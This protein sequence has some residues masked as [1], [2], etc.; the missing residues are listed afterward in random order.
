MS[1]DILQ[2][3]IK[4]FDLQRFRRFFS[5][6]NKKFRPSEDNLDYYYDDNF[7][8]GRKLGELYLEDGNL[9]I[10]AFGVK[11]EL[12]ER[13]GKK[14][15]YNLGRSILKDNNFQ[16][17]NVGIFVF[18]DQNENFRFSLIYDIPKGIHR[19]WN[20]FRRFT[21]FINKD[22]TNKTFLQRIGDGDFS[23][24][25][26]IKDAFSVEK[27]TK[28]FYK[29]IANWYFW[30]VQ[31]VKFP[32]DAEAEENGRN[33]AVIRLITRIIF[34]WFMRERGL[35]PKYLFDKKMLNNILKDISPEKPTYYL[36]ILQN[37]FFATLNTKNTER[38]FHREWGFN[39][40]N[41]PDYGDYKGY[42]Y[43]KLFKDFTKMN[44]YFGEIP[45]L[46]GGLFECLDDESKGIIVDG[47]SDNQKNQPLIPNYLFFSGELKADLNIEY[48]TKN[49]SYKVRGLI[50]TLSSYN[51]TIDEND[52]D[53]QEVALDPEL[54][55][56]VF[57]NLLASF[58]PETSTTARKATGS[59]YT[60]REIVNYMVTESLK[61]YF[62]TH[63]KD[64]VNLE[65]KLEELFSKNKEENPFNGEE[66]ERIAK[67][68]ESL[69]IVDPAV[70]SG[71]FPMGVLN[72]LVFILSKIDSQNLYWKK[73]QINAVKQNV[74]DSVVREKLIDQIEKQFQEKNIDYG[75][76]LFL[77]QKCIYGVDIQQIAVEIARLRFFIS[78]LVNE[79]IDQRHY[80]GNW[81]IQPLPNLDFK[82]MQG[83][84]LISKFMGIDFDKDNLE[85]EKLFSDNYQIEETI[86]DF[87]QK[88]SDFQSEQDRS[89]KEKLK[90]DIEKLIIKILNLKLEEKF[91]EFKAIEE[92]Y[93]KF[94]NEKER[95]KSILKEKQELSKKIGFD[96]ENAQKQLKEYAEG[97]H[98]K[99][100][101][102]W[103]LYFAEVFQG[104][105]PGFD[106]VIANPP[107][108]SVKEIKSSDKK[109]FTQIFKTG[110]GRFN[111][112]TLFLEKGNEILRQYGILIFILPEGLYSN[113]E[114]Q[115]IRRYLLENTSILLIG[116]FT[117]RVFK[118]AVDTSIISAIKTR[119]PSNPFPIVR[120]LINKISILD[121]NN[122]NK[123]PFCL[124]SV[125]LDSYSKDIV[126]KVL[127]KYEDS[128]NNIL[129]IQQGIIYSGQSK[130]K[131]F[132]NEEKDP[133]YKK[134]LDGRDV[135]KWLINWKEK[136]ENKY[137][138]YS[139]KLHRAREERLFLA[140]EKILLPRKSTLISCA[141]DE[142]QFY[143][144]NTAYVCLIKDSNYKLKFIL[145]LLN[146]VLINYFYSKLFFGWQV[147]IPALGCITV[148]K[149]EL[150]KP[151]IEIV[152]KIL[153]ITK[154]SD[155]LE[156]PTKRV[157][158]HE[159]EKQIDQMVYKL[160]DLTSEEIE[161]VENSS[162]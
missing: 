115:Y 73:V 109:L 56:R 67:L 157:K 143:I 14:A 24:L 130:E 155:Y 146:S 141:Y 28:E 87:E 20:N 140:E 99:P 1:K 46:N 100:F 74:V 9:L 43:H 89:K 19:D 42:R 153:K 57:E 48:G 2:S 121:Q 144:L 108:V 162:K 44:E 83:N 138:H 129:E 139:N 102:L 47:F 54:L 107:Y 75:R 133:T 161:I 160:Y 16:Q 114:Y 117:E 132:S 61:Q 92:K 86:K 97:L 120:D 136:R 26:K 3:I 78:L 37:L 69:R 62:K 123:L 125:N 150:Q 23:S 154:S 35:A 63:L 11:R 93:S 101:F 151:F 52:I 126:Y 36:A 45:F 90:E 4:N 145:A 33:I 116:L 76:K 128:I 71:A 142:E 72:K 81:G 30:A 27:V 137:I 50:D 59:Y 17:F 156:N 38:N 49:K 135:L 10:C 105:N 13:S 147:T 159:Y 65:E 148:P 77:I 8:N 85:S 131:V 122:F 94:P 29:D 103:K 95:K 79:K 68:I 7:S 31:N 88:K 12:S 18:Y 119:T 149:I 21:Y 91:P 106:I 32:K 34:I 96:L 112:F 66:S 84:S 60:P 55:G 58:N 134:V 53:D 25:E 39:K 41:N 127:G 113:V 124:F 111:L 104:E 80:D 110:R 82:L 118:A 152:D 40:E 158:V 51:F 6:K 64:I 5:E 70:G 15:Q 98:T 22:Q